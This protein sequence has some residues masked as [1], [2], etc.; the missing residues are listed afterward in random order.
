MSLRER[1]SVIEKKA[2]MERDRDLA[3]MRNTAGNYLRVMIGVTVKS[4]TENEI[5]GILDLAFTLTIKMVEDHHGDMSININKEGDRIPHYRNRRYNKDGDCLAYTGTSEVIS[6]STHINSSVKCVSDLDYCPYI[7]S[8]YDLSIKLNALDEDNERQK[9]KAVV[10]SRYLDDFIQFQADSVGKGVSKADFL[11]VLGVSKIKKGAQKANPALPKI[12]TQ[13]HDG[14]WIDLQDDDYETDEII[15]RFTTRRKQISNLVGVVF[16]CILVPLIFGELSRRE[17]LSADM[18]LTG[19]LTL[20]FAMPQEFG[21]GTA[22]WF[23]M[24]FMLC[25]IAYAVNMS[26]VGIL[27]EVLSVL[28]GCAL[29]VFMYVSQKHT[30][31]KNNDGGRLIAE[32]VKDKSDEWKT[33]SLGERFCLV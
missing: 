11:S 19:V 20:I 18:L 14:L 7:L 8:T 16:P 22:V 28:C 6:C 29:L 15:L 13:R 9:R 26:K 2:D 27:I 24:A 3:I 32:L 30:I 4:M 1:F 33:L 21:F 17:Q 23:G 12:A 5:D 31:V 10:V 25:L